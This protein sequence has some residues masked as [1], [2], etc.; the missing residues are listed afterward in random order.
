MFKEREAVTCI[1]VDRH[2]LATSQKTR[3][4]SECVC[5]TQLFQQLQP[6]Y[7]GKKSLPLGEVMVPVLSACRHDDAMHVRQNGI[8]VDLLSSYV[9]ASFP[10]AQF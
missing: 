2:V 7:S 4:L 1:S 3:G 5:Q 9:V 6:N 8:H 10:K